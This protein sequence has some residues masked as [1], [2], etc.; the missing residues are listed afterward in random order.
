MSSVALTKLRSWPEMLKPIVTKLVT[1]VDKRQEVA[2]RH[3]LPY[4][5]ERLEN[6]KKGGC[7]KNKKKAMDSLRWCLDSAPNAK[8]LQPKRGCI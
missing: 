8:E 6:E 5:K 3:L 2:R 4:I 7:E 1:N